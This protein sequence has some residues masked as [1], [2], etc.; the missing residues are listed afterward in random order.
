MKRP[1]AEWNVKEE[2]YK[3]KLT[4]SDI[5]KLEEYFK[6]NLLNILGS[7][8]AMPSLNSM[9]KVTHQAM[10]K[11]HHGLK[12]QDVYEIFDSYVEQGGS[13]MDFMTEVF[14]PIYQTSG[15][16]S[17]AQ[18]EKVDENLESVKEQM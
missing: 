6:T 12:L 3:L 15:F 8:K 1:Y 10:S 13:Q 17:E 4:T 11:Y 7:E 9:L 14:F 5:I 18:A 2:T 16:L